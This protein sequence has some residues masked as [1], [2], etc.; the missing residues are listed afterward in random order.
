[1]IPNKIII[2]GA[3]SSGLISA[4]VLKNKLK[5]CNIVIIRSTKP[6][7]GVGEATV[8]SFVK[9]LK[10]HMGINLDDFIKNVKPIN[11]HGIWFA[12]GKNDFHYTFDT[13]FDYHVFKEN[14]PIGFKFDGGNFGNS[15]LSRLMINNEEVFANHNSTGLHLDNKLFLKYMENECIKR[16]IKII[17]DKITS[18]EYNKI[19]DVSSLNKKYKADFFVD[20]SG[21]KSLLNKSKWVSYSKMLINDRALVFVTNTKLRPYTK[22]TTMNNGW[23]WEIDHLNSATYGYVYSS[24]YTDEKNI[25]KELKNKGM[26]V[27]NYKIIKFKT[28]RK[29]KPWIGNTVTIGNSNMFVEPLESSALMAVIENIVDVADILRYKNRGNLIE[30][31][32]KNCN[33]YYDNIRDFVFCHF[34]FNKKLNTKYWVDY[35]KRSYMLNNKSLASNVISYYK[36][37]NTNIKFTGSFYHNNPFGLEG[38]HSIL[39]GL[40]VK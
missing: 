16:G 37:N 31:Y 40:D 30:L 22:A 13:A 2:L 10:D 7:I 5:D 1:M 35:R 11:K 20:C 4:L 8:G 24:K 15:R 21:F 25:L 9:S 18:V 23:L 28:G 38:W 36:I 39:R 12:F 19:G 27:S 6:V 33:I 3:G 32:N 34:C 29:E 26:N 17:D 14:D